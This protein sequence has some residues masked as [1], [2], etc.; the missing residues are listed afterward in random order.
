MELG[1]MAK[2][3]NLTGPAGKITLAE[4]TAM[5]N[6]T[7]CSKPIAAGMAAYWRGMGDEERWCCDPD[8]THAACFGAVP[9]ETGSQLNI[10][11]RCC[12]LW[13]RAMEMGFQLKLYTI[14]TFEIQ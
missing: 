6:H 12:R 14:E 13:R 3:Y 10:L 9:V 7:G 8:G 1:K 2:A 11:L 4:V 5:W